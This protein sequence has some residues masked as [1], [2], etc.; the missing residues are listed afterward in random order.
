MLSV[1]KVGIE[2]GGAALAASLAFA[3]D[4]PHAKTAAS[5]ESTAVG[6]LDLMTI[7]SLSVRP[8]VSS[9]QKVL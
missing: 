4:Q 6:I 9:Q 5:A 3:P 8:G 7:F 2:E 1:G